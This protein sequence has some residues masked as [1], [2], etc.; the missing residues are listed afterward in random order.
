[1]FFCFFSKKD[2]GCAVRSGIGTGLLVLLLSQLATAMVGKVP[3]LPPLQPRSDSL[4]PAGHWQ[5]LF[6]ENFDADLDQWT[7]W[8]GGAYNEELQ[9]YQ[10]DNLRLT[11][12]QLRIEAVR[13]RV[14]GANRPGSA[15]T[16][17]FEFTSGRIQ[18]RAAFAPDAKMRR[19]RISARVKA[20]A[21]YGMWPA[22]WLCGDE[23]PTA[24]EVDILE[25]RGHQPHVYFTNYAYGRQAGVN[26]QPDA[27]AVVR[28]AESLTG[29]W[30]V[31]ELIWLKKR[32][33]FRLDGRVVDVKRGGHI[34]DLFGKPQ[35]LVLNLAVGGTFF[36]HPSA[37]SIQPGI[38][39]VD[40]VRV[41][42]ER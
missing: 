42:G 29:Q 31:V 20:A 28:T 23:W 7:V 17:T 5:L 40:W 38:F 12:G 19:L 16:R 1:L 2:P 22:F 24:G 26:E 30:H 6:E 11:E 34:P 4:R 35:R 14:T 21:G 25:V 27:T 9:H 13:E 15:E 41:F 36:G 18:S 8:R 33:T 32:L 3:S 39:F 37:D 10:A